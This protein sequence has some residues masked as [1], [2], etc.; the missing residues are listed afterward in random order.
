MSRDSNDRIILCQPDNTKGCSLCCGLFNFTDISPE[1]LRGFL[2]QGRG[3]EEAF[4]THNEYRESA[5]VR[6]LCSHIC[7]YQGFLSEEKPGCLIHPL[8]SGID[9]RWRSLFASKIC[10]EFF[11]PA[12]TILSDEEKKYL[13]ENV[14]NWYHYSAA[15]ADPESFSFIFNYVKDNFSVTAD[16]S[17][18]RVL[19]EEGLS[20]HA[21]NLAY[22]E[23]AIF[24]Y[25]IPEYNINK[26]YFSIKYIN[27]SR[28]LVVSRI[29]KALSA[30]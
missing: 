23:G 28:E 17:M 16:S 24:F 30:V 25:S 3:R 20:A 27:K 4:P 5:K 29:E 2:E 10:G 18:Q 13:I 19:L 1:S 21:E 22:Y 7:P 12:H 9:G 15:I 8:S 14:S 11:C 6:D 26:K